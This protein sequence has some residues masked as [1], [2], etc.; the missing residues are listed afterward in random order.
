MWSAEVHGWQSAE[1]HGWQNE[2]GGWVT[3]FLQTIA[4]D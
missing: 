3:V 4:K 1:V 2:L